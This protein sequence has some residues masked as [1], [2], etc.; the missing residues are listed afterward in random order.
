MDQRPDCLDVFCDLHPAEIVLKKRIGCGGISDIWLAS[1]ASLPCDFLVKY[2]RY[3]ASVGDYLHCQFVR[4]WEASEAMRARGLSHC[5]PR[6]MATDLDVHHHPYAYLEF[7]PGTSL[8]RL[9]PHAYHWHQAAPIIHGIIELLICLHRSGLIHGD[10][11]PG[12]I[13]VCPNDC[14]KLIDFSLCQIDGK[15]HPSH[16][17]GMALGTP[18]Y[19]SPEQARG[20][21][22]IDESDWYALGASLYEWA[23]GDVPLRGKTPSDTMYQHCTREPQPIDHCRIQDAPSSFGTLLC[24]LLSLS[25]A[26]RALAASDLYAL[27][28][29]N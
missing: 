15:R 23:T 9:L 12:N 29:M 24:S 28:A 17:T 8:D 2:S 22:A 1:H 13:L 21:R 27:T 7:C 20:E 6:V 19:I 11:K 10:L 4:E 18:L 5:A 16:K 3:R 25:P 14:V 26:T